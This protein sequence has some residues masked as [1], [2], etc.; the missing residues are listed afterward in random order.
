[1]NSKER[2]EK[3]VA[4]EV[5][6]RTPIHLRLEW[7]VPRWTGVNPQEFVDDPWTASNAL[8]TVFDKIGGWDAVDNTWTL[9][10]RHSRLEIGTEYYITRNLARLG[11]E[12]DAGKLKTVTAPAM[13][14]EDYDVAIKE[15]LYGFLKTVFNRMG[16]SFDIDVEDDIYRGFAPIYRHWEERGVVVFRGGKF[17]PPMS[18]FQWARTWPELVKDL[19]GMYGK[20]KQACDA[21]W[22]ESLSR[23]IRQS[24]IVDC[25]YVFVPASKSTLGSKKLFEDLLFPYLKEG[26]RRLVEDGFVPRIHLDLDWTPYLEYFLEL[27][28]RSCVAELESITNL[29][30]AK[31]VLGGHMCISGGVAPVLLAQGSVEAIQERCRKLIEE[32]GPDGYILAN[33]D[34]VP[35]NAKLENVK[36]LVDAGKKFGAT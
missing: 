19:M 6:D 12:M 10:A 1:M 8:E 4:C 28:K 20:V 36:A 23:G 13:I 17:K 25:K 26:C 33:D 14:A 31:E 27:P 9:A 21:T 35:P 18:Y 7:S 3:A 11:V 5:P 22:E 2:V 15:G 32:V 24:R 16:K 30:K 34:M 29:Q